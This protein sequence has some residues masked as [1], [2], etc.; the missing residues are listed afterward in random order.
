MLGK[1]AQKAEDLR[2]RVYNCVC[3]LCGMEWLPKVVRILDQNFIWLDPD[4]QTCLPISATGCNSPQA[5]KL[6]SDIL[7]TILSNTGVDWDI[8]VCV[9]ELDEHIRNVDTL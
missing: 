4:Q 5:P 2:G 6:S 8:Y 3:G 1:Y 7:T 9:Y